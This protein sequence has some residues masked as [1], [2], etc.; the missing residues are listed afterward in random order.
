MKL[1]RLKQRQS[2]ASY[3][4]V[5]ARDNFLYCSHE[6]GIAPIMRMLKRDRNYF[7]DCI[8]VDKIIG[9]AAAMLLTL[10]HVRYIH[11]QLMSVSAMRYLDQ[12]GIDYSYDECCEIIINRTHTGMC[13]M[14][15]TV[16]DINDAQAAYEA[17]VM[18]LDSLSKAQ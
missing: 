1:A 11:A 12:A 10:A 15:A 5:A 3:S 9:K 18:K 2:E 16:M 8:V 6:Q 7:Y 14:E 17:L 4:L 13:P